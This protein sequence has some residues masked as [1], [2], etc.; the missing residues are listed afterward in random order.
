LLRSSPTIHYVAHPGNS[1]EQELNA[2]ASVYAFLLKNHA[3]KKAN[4]PALGPVGRDDAKGSN[5]CI[6]YSNHS[7]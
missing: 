6:A 2:L 1:P 3:S 5:D 7:K 4:K